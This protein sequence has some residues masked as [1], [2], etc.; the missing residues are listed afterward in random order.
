MVTLN[1]VHCITG[2]QSKTSQ[3]FGLWWFLTGC[4]RQWNAMEVCKQRSLLVTECST[5]TNSWKIIDFDSDL[6]CSDHESIYACHWNTFTRLQKK[7][8]LLAWCKGGSMLVDILHSTKLCFT[9]DP[10]RRS[11]C[12][13]GS[14][15]QAPRQTCTPVRIDIIWYPGCLSII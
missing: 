4:R 11:I 7:C 12:C 3:S 13:S 15:T 6:A 1:I 9:V 5:E 14:R 8:G 10:F 2:S